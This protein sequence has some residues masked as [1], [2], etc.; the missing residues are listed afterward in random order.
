MSIIDEVLKA[1]TKAAE[2]VAQAETDAAAKI[3]VAR[4]E[5][6]RQL[7]EASQ[8]LAQAESESLH[9]Y[10]QQLE[11]E[12]SAIATD[13]KLQV[14]A[15]LQRSKNSADELKNHIVKRFTTDLS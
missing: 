5:Q 14:E 1:E 6:T 7:T 13:T 12:I 3:A 15:L 9:T 4:E 8:R 11:H 10:Q 2:M